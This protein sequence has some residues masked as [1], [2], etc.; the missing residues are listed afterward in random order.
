V[1]IVGVVE[2]VL[3]GVETDVLEDGGGLGS[4][5][6]CWLEGVALLAII[7]FNDFRRSGFTLTLRNEDVLPVSTLLGF[8]LEAIVCGQRKVDNANTI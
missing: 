6:A 8:S 5:L 4:W 7:V 2:G 3:L 1:P